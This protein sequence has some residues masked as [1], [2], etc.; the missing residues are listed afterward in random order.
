M[1]KQTLANI[2]LVLALMLLP[3]TWIGFGVV[4]S[5]HEPTARGVMV[6]GI[7]TPLSFIFLFTAAWLAG[8][9]YT[10]AKKRASISSFCCIS[11]VLA[12]IW[13]SWQR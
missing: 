13:L 10:E 8:Y 9:S 3:M 5:E 1:K 11:Y 7:L 2:A 4:L 12:L 6:L